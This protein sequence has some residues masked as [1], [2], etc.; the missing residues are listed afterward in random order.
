MAKKNRLQGGFTVLEITVTFTII[1]LI[2]AGIIKA[3][4]II[5]KSKDAT[6]SWFARSNIESISDVIQDGLEIWFD[7]AN[8]N[9][10]KNIG[11]RTGDKISQWHDLS[12]NNHHAFQSDIN[13]RPV[14]LVDKGMYHVD[15]NAANSIQN[16]MMT[17]ADITVPS[18][19][20]LFA[21]FRFDD[22][23]EQW[24][25]IGNMGHDE[26][27]DLRRYGSTSELA[28]NILNSNSPRTTYKVGSWGV[29][30]GRFNRKNNVRDIFYNK[31]RNSMGSTVYNVASDKSFNIGTT[32]QNRT[33]ENLDGG[34]R[35]ILL[36][37]RALENWE[38]ELM[39]AY[40]ANKWN[41]KDI[42]DSDGDGIVDLQ[43][44]M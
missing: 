40:L 19:V 29:F 26:L 16:Y 22:N 17:Q 33:N 4:I 11:I 36:Y 13:K 39:L 10:N 23:T 37:N 6:A 15:F 20:T 2:L 21:V 5:D 42:V 31:Y 27:F 35:E 3:T 30:A 12:G 24:S 28:W 1:A 8:V 43:D 9:G 7:A 34:I 32:V 25:R 41:L 14:L 44:N 38:I 18:S